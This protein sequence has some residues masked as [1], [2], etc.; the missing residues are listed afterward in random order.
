MIVLTGGHKKNFN[1]RTGYQKE[2][3]IK[4]YMILT[5]PPH[6][7]SSKGIQLIPK[8]CKFFIL[9]K[10]TAETKGNLFVAIST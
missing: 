9:D 8:N 6:S 4:L 7:Q 3:F 5:H 2:N 10:C 1:D